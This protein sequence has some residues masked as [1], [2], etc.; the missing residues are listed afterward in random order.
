M[1]RLIKLSKLRHIRKGYKFGIRLPN[2]IEE[3]LALDKENGNTLWEDAIMKE[4]EG[5]R[6]AF[7]AK[8]DGKPPPGYKEVKLMMI[9]DIKM[10]FTRKARLVA[11]GDL[12][13]P[14]PTLTYSSVVSR[15]SVRTA[16]TLAAL[17]DLDG[18]HV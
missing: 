14:P 9:F 2:S 6:I 7:E 17:N 8:E 18:S 4:V 16:F 10:D 1:K 3:A 15:E 13:D 11:R 12:T 5:V